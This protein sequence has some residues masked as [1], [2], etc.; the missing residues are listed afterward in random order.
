MRK[1]SVLQTTTKGKKV[2][3]TTKSDGVGRVKQP[4]SDLKMDTKVVTILNKF[5]TL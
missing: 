3:A 4:K 5:M 2:L 1:K